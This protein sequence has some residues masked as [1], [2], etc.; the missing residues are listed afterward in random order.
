MN[1]TGG[2][3]AGTQPKAMRTS[4][5]ALT[6]LL[7]AAVT[8]SCIADRPG[9][10]AEEYLTDGMRVPA[11]S[12]P[13]GDGTRFR[14]PD[15]FAGRTTLLV[16]FATWC[17]DCRAELPA[18]EACRT[19]V[20]DDPGLAVVA[21]ARGGDG[22]Y[23]QTA[24]TVASYWRNEGFAMPWYLDR[25][26]RVFDLFAEAG[27]PRI[28]VVGPDGTILHHALAPELSGPE[29]EALLRGLAE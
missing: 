12:V 21:I 16:F 1:D 27:I 22:E 29:Y 13:G 17:P 4:L 23:A 9:A 6:C 5:T 28:Y 24:E 15:D 18:V 26:R 10:E 11:F 7:A 25:D 2:L 14:S 3:S 8:V 19:A 20:A